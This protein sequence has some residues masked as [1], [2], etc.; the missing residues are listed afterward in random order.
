MHMGMRSVA[1]DLKGQGV[2]VGIIGPG[3][4]VT[5]MYEQYGEDYG[6]TDPNA[7]TPAQSV[8]LMMEII[9]GLDQSSN[10]KLINSD[11]K[12]YPF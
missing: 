9:A 10:S 3:S 5:S 6:F 7:I 1:A 2:V 11:G 12:T 4:V 8:G